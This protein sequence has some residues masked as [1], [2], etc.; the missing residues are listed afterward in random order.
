[1]ATF[2]VCNGRRT[3]VWDVSHY[4]LQRSKD[5]R[6]GRE[7]IVSALVEGQTSGTRVNSFG[8]I[9]QKED[10]CLTVVVTWE[11]TP[12]YTSVVEARELRIMPHLV[13]TV[14]FRGVIV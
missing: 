12:R 6:L 7:S 11:W 5:I 2:G 3:D 9:L 4:Y 8:H 1:M 14:P 10:T 13:W